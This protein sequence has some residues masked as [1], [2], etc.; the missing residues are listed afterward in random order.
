MKHN[1]REM[2]ANKFLMYGRGPG[3]GGR[4]HTRACNWA[5]FQYL[6]V[7]APLNCGIQYS[8]DYK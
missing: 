4:Y 8:L 6:G 2:P 7:I 5:K 1:K 3:R